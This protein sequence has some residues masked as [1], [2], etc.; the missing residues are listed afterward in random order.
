MGEIPAP[1]SQNRIRIR[2][3][4]GRQEIKLTHSHAETRV[5]THHPFRNTRNLFTYS[6]PTNLFTYW[7]MRRAGRSDYGSETY[8]KAKNSYKPE[9][10]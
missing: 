7:R 2:K 6:S 9:N 5:H 3:K 10:S 4:G 1:A 8:Q